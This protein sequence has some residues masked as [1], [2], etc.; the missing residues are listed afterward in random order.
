MSK[1]F[2]GIGHGGL[3]PGA[4]ANGLRE[5]DVNLVVGLSMS[6]ELSRNGVVTALSRT[7]DENDP[8]TEEIAE[9]NAFR[10]DLAVGDHFNA[11][12]GDGFEVYRQTNRFASQ[13]QKLA[14][15][16][17]NQ[18]KNIGQNSRGVKTR[19][20]ASG[21]DYFGWLRQ[22]NCPA[23]LCEGAFLDNKDDVQLID[24]IEKQRAFGVAY[25]RGVLDYLGI[26]WSPEKK[27]T[28]GYSVQEGFYT[29]IENAKAAMEQA[30]KEGRNVIVVEAERM[31]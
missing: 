9:A 15:A 7:T 23:V 21:T 8:L 27:P 17:E 5:A 12:G 11:G 16:I 22:V 28:A 30:K 19:I 20:N 18:V 2:I 10:P 13:S 25:A 4:I 1:V 29:K 24:T 14:Q 26:S 6:E 31:A 3:D